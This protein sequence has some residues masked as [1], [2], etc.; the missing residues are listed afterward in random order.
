MLDK[1]ELHPDDFKSVV[2]TNLMTREGY[3]PYCGNMSKCLI[4]P[5]TNFDK[6][7]G[8]FKCPIC[9]WVSQYPKDFI[10]RYTKK[11]NIK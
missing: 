11:W 1:N 3:K 8:Q 10:E 9:G 6:T 5:R 4:L 2:R 7:I